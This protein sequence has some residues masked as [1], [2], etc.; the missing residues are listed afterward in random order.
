MNVCIFLE[1]SELDSSKKSL[2]NEGK[3]DLLVKTR[4][5]DN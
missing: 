2:R 1:I 4:S 3:N 5:N